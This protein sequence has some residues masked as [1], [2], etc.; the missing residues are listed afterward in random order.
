MVGRVVCNCEGEYVSNI[1]AVNQGPALKEKENG[2]EGM[3]NSWALG[4]PN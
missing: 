1:A 3:V 2:A 4:C